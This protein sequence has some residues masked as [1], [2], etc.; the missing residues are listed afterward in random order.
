[1]NTHT[2]MNGNDKQQIQDRNYL[3]GKIEGSEIE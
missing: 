1:M 3:Q 2:H